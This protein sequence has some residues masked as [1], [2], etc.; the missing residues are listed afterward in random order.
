ME[1]NTAVSGLLCLK[2]LLGQCRSNTNLDSVL[3][4]ESVGKYVE[5]PVETLYKLAEN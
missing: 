5:N 2:A 4:K 3:S 1:K